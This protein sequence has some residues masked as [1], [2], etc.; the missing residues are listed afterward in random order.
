MRLDEKTKLLDHIK[1]LEMRFQWLKYEASR[2]DYIEA[3]EERHTKK[4]SLARLTSLLPH[5]R[6][7]LIDLEDKIGQLEKSTG[8]CWSD[9]NRLTIEGPGVDKFVEEMKSKDTEIKGFHINLHSIKKKD[10]KKEEDIKKLEEC[11]L[12]AS[13]RIGSLKD[14]LSIPEDCVNPLEYPIEKAETFQ[15]KIDAVNLEIGK[16]TKKI[17]DIKGRLKDLEVQSHELR[18]KKE[19]INEELELIDDIGKQKLNIIKKIDYHCYEATMWI[20][21]NS[22]MFKNKVSDPVLLEISPRDTDL[23]P[24]VESSLNRSALMTFVTNSKSDW[25]IIHEELIL[26]KKLRISVV[27]TSSFE[28]RHFQYPISI[29]DVCSFSPVCLIIPAIFT[30]RKNGI[31]RIRFRFNRRPKKSHNGIMQPMQ[32]T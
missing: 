32:S 10:L 11:I 8:G 4:A 12:K 31:R 6:K 19:M 29:E 18:K 9:I 22:H 15:K 24:I 1:K 2:T 23:A 7:E 27:D 28:E 13:A 5:L 30:D 3:K 14:M 20:R 26:K 25:Y 21:Q 16:T 17:N